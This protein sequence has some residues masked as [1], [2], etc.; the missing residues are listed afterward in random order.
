MAVE[1]DTFNAHIGLANVIAL[2]Y[3]NIPGVTADEAISE[4]HQALLRASKAFDPT[5]GEFAP[6]SARS[7]RNAPW[8]RGF[9][10]CSEGPSL[11]RRDP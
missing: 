7:I 8:R 6:Y 3:T 9:Q 4:A 10:I 11:L 2:E 1:A 5:K